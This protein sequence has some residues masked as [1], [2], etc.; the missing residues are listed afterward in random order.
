[1]LI[2]QNYIFLKDILSKKKINRKILLNRI[3]RKDLSIYY[4]FLQISDKNL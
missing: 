3:V 2:S 4:L 1:M